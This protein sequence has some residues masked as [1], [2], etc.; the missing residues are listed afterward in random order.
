MSA[1]RAR[2]R[3]IVGVSADTYLLGARN[4]LTGQFPANYRTAKR[5]ICTL[6]WGT[7][8]RSRLLL[9]IIPA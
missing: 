8:R 1:I 4:P 2:G 6:H 7:E 9:P 5:G 3:L